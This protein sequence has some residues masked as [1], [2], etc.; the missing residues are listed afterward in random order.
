MKKS[1]LALAVL[2]AFAGAASAQSSVTLYGVAD[3]NFTSQKGSKADGGSQRLNGIN[4]GGLQ[5]SRWGLRGTEDL[6]G[7]AR[8]TF[9]LESGFNID[10]GSSAQGGLLFGRHA[11][12]GV[13]SAAIGDVRL[14]R[15]LTPLGVATDAIGNLGTKS[16]DIFAVARTLG[17]GNGGQ[18]ATGGRIDA[19][20]TDNSITYVSPNWA[21]LTTQL[22][23]STRA[24]GA[25]VNKPANKFLE[26]IG[27]NV[28]FNAGPVTAGV[29]YLN[30]SD[31]V[32]N[33][34][35]AEGKQ[36]ATGALVYAGATF[37]MFTVRGAYNRDDFKKLGEAKVRQ[38]YGLGADVNLAPVMLSFGYG[39]AK[40][41]RG[42][43]AAGDA[44]KDDANIFNVQA[45]YDLSKRTSLYT[46]Y[47]YVDNEKASNLGYNGVALGKK[48][49]QLQIG[50]RHRF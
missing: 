16:A 49:D 42:S 48:S 9:T 39:L 15:T 50:L 38:T 19:Y 41:N 10:Q 4:S 25:E 26:H 36:K 35:G 30:I 20:R 12:V 46:F 3:A 32:A 21:G 7:G 40:D 28:G 6:G 43:N 22:Q 31:A 34:T 45:V 1:L 14:G 44:N 37:G 18:A 23:Y 13:G 8:A 17:S 33:V 11:W 2:G 24:A 47:T 5:G 29:A 27:F